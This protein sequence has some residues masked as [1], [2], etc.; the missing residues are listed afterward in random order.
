MPEQA[1]NKTA[2]QSVR[3]RFDLYERDKVLI[4]SGK[5][6]E[7]EADMLAMT[8][9]ATGDGKIDLLS[10]EFSSGTR[11]VIIQRQELQ[12]LCQHGRGL[13]PPRVSESQPGRSP[14]TMCHGILQFQNVS[15]SVYK[16]FVKICSSEPAVMLSD[17]MFYSGCDDAGIQRSGPCL[18]RNSRTRTCRLWIS[19]HRPVCKPIQYLP[20]R[21]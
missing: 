16:E 20:P 1:A 17:G 5:E 4:S 19:P 3:L 6:G 14:F 13:Q 2:S 15:D 11:H 9:S 18:Y 21:R 10:Y 7:T 12:V 8:R